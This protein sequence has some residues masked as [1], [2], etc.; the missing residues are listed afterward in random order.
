MTSKKIRSNRTFVKAL[1]ARI[2][3]LVLLLLVAAPIHL[4][5]QTSGTGAIE[6][7]VPT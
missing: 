6:G 4:I 3:L 2:S 7:T 1:C 5:A